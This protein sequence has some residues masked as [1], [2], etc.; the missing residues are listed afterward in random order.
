M[1]IIKEKGNQNIG[2]KLNA[3]KPPEIQTAP[4]HNPMQERVSLLERQIEEYK[5]LVHLLKWELSK[6]EMEKN[7]LKQAIADIKKSHFDNSRGAGR[8]PKFTIEQ[9]DKIIK[10]RQ[11]GDTISAI[12]QKYNCSTGLVHKLVIQKQK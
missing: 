3:Y 8:K 9:I 7:Y 4:F 2:Q 12:A 10:C 1:I 5:N 11:N 6:K